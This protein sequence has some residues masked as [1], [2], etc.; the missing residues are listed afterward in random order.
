MLW[1]FNERMNKSGFGHVKKNPFA[2][3]LHC[4]LPVPRTETTTGVAQP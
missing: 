3:V 4:T 1:P 2:Q